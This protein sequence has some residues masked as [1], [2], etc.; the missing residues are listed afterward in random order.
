MSIKNLLIGTLTASLWL[1][2][3]MTSSFAGA[4]QK[5]HLMVYSNPV[6]GK[7]DSYLKWYKDSI[8]TIF[9][10]FRASSP[11]NS[12]SCRIPNASERSRSDT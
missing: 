9:S 2:A 3:T 10:E 4:K 6:G 11:R 8:S 1:V 12:S 5:Y 7:E